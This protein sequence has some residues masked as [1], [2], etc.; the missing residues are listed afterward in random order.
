MKISFYIKEE[1]ELEEDYI[2]VVIMRKA[3]DRR[4]STNIKKLDDLT[5]VEQQFIKNIIVTAEK[6]N[7]EN[8]GAINIKYNL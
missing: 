1:C 7:S 2:S 5:A 3:N 8:E 6:Y 4:Q